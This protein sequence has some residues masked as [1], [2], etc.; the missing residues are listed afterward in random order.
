MNVAGVEPGP[1]LESV[2][3]LRP[4]YFLYVSKKSIFLLLWFQVQQSTHKFVVITLIPAS[5]ISTTTCFSLYPWRSS[6]REWSA[7]R[8]SLYIPLS[9]RSLSSTSSYMPSVLMLFTWLSSSIFDNV[10]SKVNLGLPLATSY[11]SIYKTI[12]A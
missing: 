8:Y 10:F 1:L 11:L 9:P 5:P 3:P 12:N 2:Q 7:K 4:I 6:Q